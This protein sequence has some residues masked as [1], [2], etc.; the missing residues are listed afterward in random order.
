MEFQNR[1]SREEI[2]RLANMVVPDSSI[3]DDSNIRGR[4][5][6]NRNRFGGRSQFQRRKQRRYSPYNDRESEQRGVAMNP[7]TCYPYPY[8]PYCLNPYCPR[9]SYRHR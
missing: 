5:F 7:Q 4:R 9:H 1:L 6:D 3:T 2:I 8:Y